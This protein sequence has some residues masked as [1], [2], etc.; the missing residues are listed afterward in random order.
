MQLTMLILGY[1]TPFSSQV[2]G[3]YTAKTSPN[4]R[5]LYSTFLSRPQDP[6]NQ[7]CRARALSFSLHWLMD[8]PT[9]SADAFAQF[10][11][12][13]C[14]QLMLLV[15]LPCGAHVF[16]SAQRGVCS[17]ARCQFPGCEPHLRLES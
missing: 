13:G 10:K 17:W 8:Y 15:H 2:E 3:L 7:Y 11:G 16:D 1:A 14:I 9:N 5:S 4:A 12:S 6:P